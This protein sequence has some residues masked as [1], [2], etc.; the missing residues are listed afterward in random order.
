M[1]DNKTEDTKIDEPNFEENEVHKSDN[2]VKLE[3]T[4]FGDIFLEK[5][6]VEGCSINVLVVS[7]SK[8]DKVGWKS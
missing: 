1:E 3:E 2:I 4:I 8:Q 7:H 5:Y 6:K